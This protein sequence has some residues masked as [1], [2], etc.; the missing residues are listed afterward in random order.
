MP[1]S[2]A[3]LCALLLGAALAPAS[4]VAEGWLKGGTGEV[5]VATAAEFQR[6][7]V[8]ARA[9]QAIVLAPGTYPRLTI[10]NIKKGGDQFLIIRSADP[11]RP[12][13]VAGFDIQDSERIW[14][15]QLDI[16]PAPG[17]PTR[18]SGAIV[19]ARNGAHLGLVHSELRGSIDRDWGN[20]PD[21][22]WFTLVDNVTFAANDLHDLGR[23]VV[24]G[25]ARGARVAQ[26]RFVDIRSDG[27]DFSGVQN[28][29][30]D[31]NFFSSFHPVPPDHPDFIQ[32]WQKNALIADTHT[33][34]I[35]NN[36]MLHGDGDT[37]SPQAIFIGN[38]QP[39]MLYRDF[40]VENNIIYNASAHG[41]SL[42]DMVGGRVANNTV[43]MFPGVGGY[44]PRINLYRVRGIEVNDNVVPQ[45]S[46]D[47]AQVRLDNNL[48]T[49][50]GRTDRALD[51]AHLFL[52]A[53][54]AARATAASFTPMPGGLLAPSRGRQFGA[55]P[56]LSADWR[57]GV[58]VIG[59]Q[60]TGADIE[61]D[62]RRND[63]GGTT[64]YLWDFGDHTTAQG[65]VVSHRYARPGTYTVQLTVHRGAATT[66]GVRHVQVTQ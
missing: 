20:D 33:V 49:N 2:F 43:V 56:L 4:A 50:N 12:A 6:A 25:G 21:G 3:A 18:A 46:Q 51:P 53:G 41:I 48:V 15:Q 36:V 10:R 65:A 31:G 55:V 39:G 52:D 30:I 23:G 27:A 8:S 63:D 34:A 64:T 1:R 26:N 7:L 40:V 24:I 60:Q 42:Y 59:V 29:E 62:A 61:L 37:M 66:R 38:D 54:A 11:A 22:A 47:A 14:L 32:F 58:A 57:D 13:Q 35:R 19:V 17:T 28:V 9:G 5:R 16:G 44:P 45:I